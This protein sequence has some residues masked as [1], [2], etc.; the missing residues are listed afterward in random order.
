VELLTLK[1]LVLVYNQD[2]HQ[3]ALVTMAV[4]Q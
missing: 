4:V 3:V 1:E 2:L